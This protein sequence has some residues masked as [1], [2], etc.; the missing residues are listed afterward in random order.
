MGK[1]HGPETPGCVR[2]GLRTPR[3]GVTVSVPGGGSE[4]GGKA[5]PGKTGWSERR[6]AA[7]GAPRPA[8]LSGAGQGKDSRLW[9]SCRCQCGW[10]RE[11]RGRGAQSREVLRGRQRWRLA[12]VCSAS[13]SRGRGHLLTPP[14]LPPEC[15]G[16]ASCAARLLPDLLARVS[17]G[18]GRLLRGAGGVFLVSYRSP[19]PS[20]WP[21]PIFRNSFFDHSGSPGSQS[22]SRP[23]PP[24]FLLPGSASLGPRPRPPR[25]RSQPPGRSPPAS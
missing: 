24:L 3:A 22:N 9:G 6:E 12:R 25:A 11:R 1:T 10:A 16:T 7:P 4:V 20:G 5:G 2:A 18:R 21:P 15:G 14:S 8:Q 19:T 23:P 13:P 17:G